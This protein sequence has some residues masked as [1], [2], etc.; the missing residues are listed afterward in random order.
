MKYYKRVA[1]HTRVSKTQ[2]KVKINQ[3]K[4]STIF[5]SILPGH[6]ENTEKANTAEHWDSKGRHNFQLH[7]DGF[8]NATTYHEAIE[9]I[10]KGHKVGLQAQTVHLQ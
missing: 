5:E 4:E 6:F 9:T 3:N 2:Q 8:N 7:Q 1:N 10:E